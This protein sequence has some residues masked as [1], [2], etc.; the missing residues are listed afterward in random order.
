MRKESDIQKISE[1]I[2]KQMRQEITEEEKL[3]LANWLKQ[4]NKNQELYVRIQ[5]ENYILEQYRLKQTI[6]TDKAWKHV[7]SFPRRRVSRYFGYAATILLLLG[8][9]FIYRI[10]S[11]TEIKPKDV[12]AMK[13][14]QPGVGK[15]TLIV[16]NREEIQLHKNC[17]LEL[18]DN[19][20]TKYRND[21]ATLY[22]QTGTPENTTAQTDNIHTLVIGRGGEY[23]VML[24]DGT[25]VHLNSDSKLRYPVTFTRSERRVYLE[26]EAYFEVSRDERHPFIVEGKDFAVQ[27]LGTS[28]N[29][30]NYKDD[31]VSRVVLLEGSVQVKKANKNYKLKP[32][33][34]LEISGDDISIKKTNARNA[35]SWKNDKFYFSNE[36]LEVVM[37][38]LAR[39]Y[40]VNLFY[41]NQTI[42]DYHFTGFIPKYADIT[43]AFRVLELT[44]DVKF[45][46]KDRTVTIMRI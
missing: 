28:F 33:E 11:R 37:M 20:G 18:T 30:S 43:K 15:A 24:A 40:D 19:S 44:A 31:D 36:R 2:L 26:G 45:E 29:I 4:S 35:I 16:S 6:D 17:Q 7:T 1:L 42:K 38:K 32:D 12:V 13:P 23:C 22:Y 14:I 27:V 8:T 25:K 3:F 9:Y 10:E 46:V 41:T 5:N 39:W 34:A 21:S